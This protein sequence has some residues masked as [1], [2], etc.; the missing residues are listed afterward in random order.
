MDCGEN[1]TPNSVQ[2]KLE[3]FIPMQRPD[4]FDEA[5]DTVLIL[6][7]RDYEENGLSPQPQS[8]CFAS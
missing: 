8:Q 3:T 6:Q 2:M 7:D 4:W 1:M 5:H